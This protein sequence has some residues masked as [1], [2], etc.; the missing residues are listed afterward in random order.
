M[1]VIVSFHAKNYKR[2]SDANYWNYICQ[3]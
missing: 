3:V 2:G 1:A